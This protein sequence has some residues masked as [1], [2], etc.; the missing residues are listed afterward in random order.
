MIKKKRNSQGIRS[1][2]IRC[3]VVS[4]KNA[5]LI[6]TAGVVLIGSLKVSVLVL[7]KTFKLEL[8]VKKEKFSA[9]LHFT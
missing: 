7:M 1:A 6:D 8:E 5:Y 2:A 4:Q 3:C 9:P